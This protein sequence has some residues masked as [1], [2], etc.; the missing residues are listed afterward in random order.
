MGRIRLC[1]RRAR[2]PRPAGKVY[3]HRALQG[4]PRTG[5]EASLA[6]QAF[7]AAARAVSLRYGQLSLAGRNA[8][9]ALA[10]SG[11]GVIVTPQK[12][13]L[14]IN[15]TITSRRSARFPLAALNL[16]AALD[17]KYT[18]SIIAG[19]V[20]RDF[21]ST[22]LRALDGGHVDAVGVSVMGGPQ[23]RAAIAVS[24]AIRAKVPAMPIVWGGHYPTI[25]A[26]P[27]LH[28]PYVDYAIRGQGED[29]R[30]EV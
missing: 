3:A 19:N 14:L 27:A 15:P 12:H 7:A 6:Q 20:D 5:V 24:R 9:Y 1:G 28:S 4:L 8:L 25:C 26:E 13:I 30:G 23:L 16:S 17:G 29:T 10:G 2:R 11:S 22:A 21:V 18:S